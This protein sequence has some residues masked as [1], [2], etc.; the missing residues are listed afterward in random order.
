MTSQIPVP[1]S[2]RAD[3]T[4]PELAA[5]PVREVLGD[6][7][8]GDVAYRRLGIVNVAFLGAPG[9][10]AGNWVLVDAGL[11]GTADMIRE[12]A[13]ERFAGRRD[14]GRGEDGGAGGPCP[15]A[16]IVM[17]HGHFDH[18]GAL[19]DLAAGWDVPVFAHPREAPY[20]SGEE[21]YP[22]PDPAAGG[23]L[24]SLSSVLF[25]RGPVDVGDRLAFLE[26]DG[27]PDGG[28]PVPPLPGWRWL[29]T[30]GH[31][32]GHVSFWRAS[33]RTLLSGDAVISTEQE[34]AY[35]ALTQREEVHG[36]PMYF[37]PD[38]PAAGGSARRL[39]ALEPETLVT[40]HGR[41]LAGPAMRAALHELADR[42]EEV[43]VPKR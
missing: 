16:A 42:F 9:C 33:D 38:W 14:A 43:A 39:A 22:P 19:E 7:A 27:D 8:P 41:A 32:A 5:G 3:E 13:R 28:G 11:P 21:K 20:L 26:T 15:P 23:G 34:S 35:A 12:A 40:G 31:T 10:G 30:P 37:T 1:E 36:P 25:P 24:M 4:P 2:A 29:P 17:T 6:G 18:V